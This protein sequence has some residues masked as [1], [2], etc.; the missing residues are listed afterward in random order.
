MVSA[1]KLEDRND[2][3]PARP[4]IPFADLEDHSIRD[5]VIKEFAQN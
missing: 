1:K 5:Q 3:L 4:R 2:N